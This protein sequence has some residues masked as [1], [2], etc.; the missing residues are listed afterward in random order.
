MT[1]F[2]LSCVAVAATALLTACGGS[3]DSPHRGD[4]LEP[5]VAV[6][7]L[8]AAQIDAAT[9]QSGLQA[10]S[11]KARC[12]VKVVT[13]NYATAG[14]KAGEQTN[15]SGV[16]L[17]PGGA[18]TGAAAL[19][20]YAKGTDVE[21]PRTL[22]NPQ[23]DETFLLAAMYAAQGYAVVA[24]DYLGFAKSKYPYHPYLHADSEAT[25]VLDAMR[26]A[27]EAAPAVGAKLSGKL[28][29]TG[30]SQGGHAAMAAQRAAERD[31]PKEFNVVAGAYLAGPYNLSGQVASGVAIAGEQF[32]VPYL[33]TAWQKVYGTVYSDARTVFKLP[34]S[35][36]I[37]NLLPS[38]TLTY[39]TLVTS[40]KLPGAPGQTPDQIRDQIFQPAFLADTQNNPSDPLFL[41][42]KKNDLLGWS[43]RAPV[44]LC[45]GAADPTVPPVLHQQ[46]LK[47]DFDRRGVTN[48]V[49]VDVDAQI[50]AAYGPAPTDPTSEAFATYYGSYHRYYEPP[51]CHA[52]ARA[53]FDAVR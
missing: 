50:Q 21:K 14:V 45:G 24:T 34:Y 40:G 41:A 51:F 46:V 36:Y 6:A 52:Q 32:F 7:T 25:S 29:L 30:F 33:V 42:A 2:R 47:A 20:G 39:D 9:A 3:D 19:V 37:E 8:T 27:R 31:N 48:V 15:A 38:P 22:A 23:D 5:P 10:L 1:Y 44:L 18:C 26:A 28:M 4:L 43:P 11:G 16:L 17:V 49:S 13:L 53:R 12:D 35:G